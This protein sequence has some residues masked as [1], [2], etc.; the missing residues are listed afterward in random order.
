M[1][2]LAAA[3]RL[4]YEPY[5]SA[6]PVEM[7]KNDSAEEIEAVISAAYRQVLG[8]GHLMTSE[9]LTSAE[10]L[11]RNRSITVKDFI[12]AIA[13][14]EVYRNKFFHTQP[15]NEYPSGLVD[16]TSIE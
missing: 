7:R 16:I 5:V 13:L 12:R 11:L 6:N 3:Q 1:S 15:Q 14:S 10:S 8:N 2:S 9:R 4:G